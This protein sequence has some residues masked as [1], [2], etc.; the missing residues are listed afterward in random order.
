MNDIPNIE[1]LALSGRNVFLRLDLNAPIRD[2]IVTSDARLKAAIPSIKYAMEQGAQV[3]LGS[4]LGRPKGKR[5]PDFSLEP[6]GQRLSELLET[7]VALADSCIGDGVA[8]LLKQVTHGVVLLE[9][10]RFH[11]GET[12]NDS[13]FA[14]ELARPFDVYVN[15][16]FG[17]SHRSHASIVGMPRH[18]TETGAGFLVSREVKALNKLLHE[19]ARPFVAVV[20]GAK[21]FDKLGVLNA[22]LQRVDTLCIGGAMA[23]TFMRASGVSVGSS[24]VEE[25]CLRL[26]TDVLGRARMRGVKIL[27][28]VDHVVADH[29]GEDASAKVL[30]E[31]AIAAGWMGLDIGPDTCA[32]YGEQIA[33]AGSVFWNGPMGVFEW[34]QFSKGTMSLAA[35]LSNCSG[36]TVVGGGDS[37]A[38]VE[39]ADIVSKIDHVSTGG[40]ASLEFLEH[41]NLP[42]I[43]VLSRG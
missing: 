6:I 40:G 34:R 10:L 25:D 4:H 8:G 7:D 22:L 29:F 5:N 36:Y 13:N 42:G 24:M 26:A 35:A 37:V 11:A 28:P 31:A 3:A 23:Y 41:G 33:G 27:L 17:A 21:V 32:L 12:G 20:G 9:N 18:L 1:Q 38:A 14:R 19:P 43:D 39:K 30:P 16:A 2:G 15:D